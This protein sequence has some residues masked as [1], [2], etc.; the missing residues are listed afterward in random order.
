MPCEICG[1]AKTHKHRLH[2]GEWGG[3]YRKSNVAHLCH[4]CHWEI[5]FLM[6]HLMLCPPP[7]PPD[8]EETQRMARC[9]ANSALWEFWETRS[10]PALEEALANGAKRQRKQAPSYIIERTYAPD[11]AR[12][13]AAVCFLLGLPE[14]EGGG[15]L[16][17]PRPK[18][19][20]I[21]EKA[22]AAEAA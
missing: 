1:E 13:R 6:N 15:R 14:T 21:A 17:I 9:Q 5:H 4:A 16:Y 11:H 12:M 18:P 7:R 3:T 10:R 19:P 8:E 22:E 2:P 20:V